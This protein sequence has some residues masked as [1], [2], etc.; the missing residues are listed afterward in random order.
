MGVSAASS[1]G[2]ASAGPS[3][4]S[5]PAWVGPPGPP[6]TGPARWAA[7]GCAARG[8]A[9]TRREHQAR[10]VRGRGRVFDGS[11]GAV[12]ANNVAGASTESQGPLGTIWGGF[13]A[14]LGRVQGGFWAMVTDSPTTGCPRGEAARQ[15]IQPADHAAI[16]RHLRGHQ[17]RRCGLG[18]DVG[19]RLFETL[20]RGY[21]QTMSAAWHPGQCL[22]VGFEDGGPEGAAEVIEAGRVGGSS[23]PCGISRPAQLRALTK[24]LRLASRTPPW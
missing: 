3:F 20:A 6:P 19:R 13:G 18:A 5:V 15:W 17:T 14:G 8:D 1:F 11:H 16:A 21:D 23:G 12:D 24:T 22:T 4:S 2:A 7:R 10:S 9:K